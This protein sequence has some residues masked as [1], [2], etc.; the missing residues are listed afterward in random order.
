[1]KD[2]YITLK[3]VENGWIINRN[4]YSMQKDR[5]RE[6]HVARSD[7]ELLLIISNMIADFKPIGNTG[8]TNEKIKEN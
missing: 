7:A 5:V 8:G 4:E 1:M 6:A 3:C 2:D